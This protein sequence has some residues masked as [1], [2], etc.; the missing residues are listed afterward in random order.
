MN[1]QSKKLFTGLLVLLSACVFL[2]GCSQT[3][4]RD[5]AVEPVADVEV[6]RGDGTGVI[7]SIGILAASMFDFDSAKLNEEGTL[8]APIPQL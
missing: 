6:L 3:G 8:T 7:A 5:D 4:T 1:F 2:T